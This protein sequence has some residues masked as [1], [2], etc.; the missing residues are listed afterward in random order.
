M[1]LISTFYGIDIYMYYTD[2]ARHYLPHIHIRYGEFEAVFDIGKGVIIR[3]ELPRSQ[4]RLVQAWIEI[5]RQELM[6]NWELASNQKQPGRIDPL[7]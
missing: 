7:K 3:G 4:A 1:P 2:N 5:H 6:D